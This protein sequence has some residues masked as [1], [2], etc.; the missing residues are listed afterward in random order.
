MADYMFPGSPRQMQAR[1][2]QLERRVAAL[3]AALKPFANAA[4]EVPKGCRSTLRIWTGS[5]NLKHLKAATTDDLL[6]A[7]AALKALLGEGENG[8]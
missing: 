6:A 8:G 7:K 3:E 2:V 5:D 4:G 1:I